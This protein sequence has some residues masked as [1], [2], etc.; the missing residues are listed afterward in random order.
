MKLMPLSPAVGLIA[1]ATSP[2]S[3][4]SRPLRNHQG[5]HGIF[6]ADHSTSA[7]SHARACRQGRLDAAHLLCF[8][9]AL[10]DR[11]QGAIVLWQLLTKLCLAAVADQAVSSSKAACL[12]ATG[13]V[14]R[15]TAQQ[16]ICF[17]CHCCLQR[18]LSGTSTPPA[19][20]LLMDISACLFPATFQ[21]TLTSAS[22]AIHRVHVLAGSFAWSDAQAG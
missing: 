9:G 12:S 11:L 10:C 22:I 4:T 8:H 20:K 5:R 15:T 3:L 2:H 21:R 7:C 1:A 17:R 14:T 19:C 13:V 6:D 18:L 16:Q